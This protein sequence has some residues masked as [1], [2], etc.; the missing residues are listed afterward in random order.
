MLLWKN[1]RFAE[2]GFPGFWDIFEY[3]FFFSQSFM[4]ESVEIYFS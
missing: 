3:L 4:L 2:R 1:L